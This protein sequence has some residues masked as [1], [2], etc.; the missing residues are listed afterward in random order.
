[1]EKSAA[2]HRSGRAIPVSPRTRDETPLKGIAMARRIRSLIT[3]VG[4]AALLAAAL[5]ACTTVPPAD[6]APAGGGETELEAA[7]LDGG[8]MVALVTMGSSTCVPTAVVGPYS[9]GVLEVT[10]ADDPEA[11]ACTR[12]LVPQVNLLELPPEVD[13]TQD[14]EIRVTGDGYGGDTD[15]DGISGLTA[16]ST[17]DSLPSAG[18]LDDGAF[19]ILTWGSSSCLPVVASSEATGPSEVTVTFEQP[20]QDQACTMDFVPRGTLASV[21]GLEDDDSATL[22]LVGDGLDATGITILG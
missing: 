16:G 12:D 1:M 20:A 19:V 22:T 10:L 4:V 21:S 18:W 13:P 15:L 9:A 2:H 14:L 17:T 5:A 6:Q 11:T 7:W 3:G 8:R